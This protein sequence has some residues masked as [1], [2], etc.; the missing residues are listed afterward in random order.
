M[1]TQSRLKELLNYDHETGI[2][3]WITG[4]SKGGFKAG[5]ECKCLDVHGYIQ[6]NLGKNGS[7][8]KAHRLAWLYTYGCL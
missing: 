4:A 7:V 8:Q 5:R 3:N 6:I 2:F 1:I